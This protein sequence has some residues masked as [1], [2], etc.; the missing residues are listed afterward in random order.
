MTNVHA[1]LAAKGSTP[2]VFLLGWG[3]VGVGA[4]KLFSRMLSL[5]TVVVLL[6]SDNQMICVLNQTKIKK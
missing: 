5:S 6:E 3:W 4:Q 1:V 2:F